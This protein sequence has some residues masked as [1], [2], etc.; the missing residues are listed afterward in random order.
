MIAGLVLIIAGVVLVQR[1]TLR[2]A[3][4]AVPVPAL[5]GGE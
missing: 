5:A 1:V 4:V 2:R 3:T